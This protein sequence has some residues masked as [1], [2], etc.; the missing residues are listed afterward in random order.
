MGRIINWAKKTYRDFLDAFDSVGATVPAAGMASDIY[1]M[2]AQHQEASSPIAST[3]RMTPVPP[4]GALDYQ[5]ARRSAT[6][7]PLG[8]KQTEDGTNVVDDSEL[9]SA[10]AHAKPLP[11]PLYMRQKADGT[12]IV[13]D[14]E[15]M[16]GQDAPLLAAREV[17]TATFNDLPELKES[18]VRTASAP[19]KQAVED[20]AVDVSEF[21][22]AEPVATPPSPPKRAPK[23]AGEEAP[24][25]SWE[26]I[27][28]QDLRQ[29]EA[30][31]AEILAKARSI[32]H[33][34]SNAAIKAELEADGAP[35]HLK[36]LAALTL[37]G[38]KLE[39]RPIM[40][41]NAPKETAKPV[42]RLAKLADDSEELFNTAEWAAQAR[43]ALA[44]AER[45]PAPSSLHKPPAAAAKPLTLTEKIGDFMME[46]ISGKKWL[47]IAATA[48]GALGMWV[49]SS[50]PVAADAKFVEVAQKDNVV[51][52]DEVTI[53]P[54]AD[55]KQSV[56]Q[57]FMGTAAPDAKPAVD[58]KAVLDSG[59]RNFGHVENVDLWHKPHVQ[60]TNPGKFDGIRH[61]F[62]KEVMENMQDVVINLDDYGQGLFAGQKL[63]DLQ[64]IPG[65][66]VAPQNQR[67]TSELNQ[68]D[69]TMIR[70]EGI[71][72]DDAK[73][74][75]HKIVTIN[76][77]GGTK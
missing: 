30:K 48:M 27:L 73:A 54:G 29:E 20:D 75:V 44:E 10:T 47:A 74:P 70:R 72:K 12:H 4:P 1:A 58:A 26:Q 42:P 63:K 69:G 7:P 45:P 15:L 57:N 11:P 23:A 6:P 9:I 77:P 65:P 71:R 17:R 18:E 38:Q 62:K 55:F 46:K 19:A 24:L 34:G 39:P 8:V 76:P 14:R 21:L 33:K 59:H 13:D 43:K 49:A 56:K 68:G 37:A 61:D 5:P 2:S 35:A 66:Q 28:A 31:R 3:G 22:V 41:V 51:H 36:E 40:S 16:A 60:F 32:L 53:R 64:A 25:P 52:A 50:R 67:V